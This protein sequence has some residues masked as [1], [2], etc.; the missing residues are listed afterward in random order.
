M[1][2][3]ETS[4]NTN[5]L[6]VLIVQTYYQDGFFAEEAEE[7][8]DRNPQ[9]LRLR[10]KL[11]D[12]IATKEAEAYKKG[13]TAGV[14]DNSLNKDELVNKARVVLYEEIYTAYS[15]LSE[16]AFQTWMLQ[17]GGTL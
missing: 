10:D 11:K 15:D 12:Y 5:E 6:D 4:S 8:I 9:L 17:K 2:N 1:T 7:E 14:I 3:K 16:V 13:Y